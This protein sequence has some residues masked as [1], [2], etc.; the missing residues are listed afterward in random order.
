MQTDMLSLIKEC[1]ASL[2]KHTSLPKEFLLGLPDSDDWSLI[3]KLHSLVELSLNSL[4]TKAIG[5]GRVSEIVMRLDTSDKLRGKMAF[6]KA[7]EL[8]P[9]EARTFVS[10]LSELR[11][12]LVHD[13]SK[14]N[15]S[16]SKWIK[17]MS[18]QDLSNFTNPLF[19]SS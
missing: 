10:K 3:I 2:A 4:V 8:L 7:L 9:S 14:F 16:L 6:I 19:L 17:E 18:S 5:D 15:F 12:D 11:N 1:I 13:I